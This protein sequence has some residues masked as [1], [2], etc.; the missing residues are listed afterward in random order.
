ML[1]LA[2]RKKKE[3]KKIKLKLSLIYYFF[4]CLFKLIV[5]SLVRHGNTPHKYY[6]PYTN[7]V[8]NDHLNI[9]NRYREQRRKENVLNN[10]TRIWVR[11]GRQ[12][13][14]DLKGCDHFTL[15]RQALRHVL[16]LCNTHKQHAAV[17]CVTA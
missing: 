6:F 17:F 10:Y 2:S 14:E 3:R 13:E 4:Q 9:E 11:K 8:K 12:E 1:L 5:K 7:R 16:T 15:Y